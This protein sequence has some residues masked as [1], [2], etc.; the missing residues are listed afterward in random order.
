MTGVRAR[1]L[2]R[3]AL[4]LGVPLLLMVGLARL[5]QHQ[6]LYPAPMLEEAV[7]VEGAEEWSLR[8]GD[9]VAVHALHLASA[10]AARTLVV[11]HGNGELAEY[12]LEHARQLVRA[13]LSVV[14]VE[15]RGYG[16]ARASGP[17]TE[18]GL[19]QD[20]RAVLDELAR[21][22]TTAD[23]TVLWGTSLGTGVAAQMAAE[24]RARSLVLFSPF[25]SIPAVA[26]HLGRGLPLG[27]LVTDRFATLEKTASIT[28]PTWIVHGDHDALVPYSMGV[29]LAEAL[30]DAQLHTVEGGH[31]DDLFLVEPS[32]HERLIDLATQ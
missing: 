1:K 5:L 15:Y 21:R 17:P 4:R 32:L 29:A 10:G 6:I 18:A 25:T 14:L 28:I 8:A 9:G 31:H 3:W 26:D 24:G 22:G 23:H 13:G 16:R 2:G 12:R 11:L 20:A 7:S 19:Y 30:P 27:W